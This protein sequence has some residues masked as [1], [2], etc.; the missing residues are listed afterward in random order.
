VSRLQGVLEL[1][2]E[3]GRHVCRPRPGAIREGYTTVEVAQLLGVSA[4]QVRSWIYAGRVEASRAEV[5]GVNGVQPWLL[6][7]E[8][9]EQLLA[10][11]RSVEVAS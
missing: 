6:T 11:R 1:R 8:T 2:E 10:A 9:V 3:D 4:V 5:Q 7:R